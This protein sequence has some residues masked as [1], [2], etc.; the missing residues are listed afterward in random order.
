[1]SR[2][3]KPLSEMMVCTA[4]VLRPGNRVRSSSQTLLRLAVQFQQ[5]LV[6]RAFKAPLCSRT[7]PPVLECGS[8]LSFKRKLSTVVLGL[9]LLPMNLSAW[10]N[11]ELLIWMDNDRAKGLAPIAQKFQNDFG[12]KI[13]IDTPEK[14]PRPFQGSA[15]LYATSTSGSLGTSRSNRPDR[16]AP[17]GGPR[18]WGTVF[19]ITPDP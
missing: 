16:A 14:L 1:M 3:A 2:S 18:K 12:L 8:T 17:V 4:R 6:E 15:S 10:T 19:Q 13:T 7:K 11:G 9:A 5:A